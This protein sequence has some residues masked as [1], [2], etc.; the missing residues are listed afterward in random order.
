MVVYIYT[1]CKQIS[2]KFLFH[3]TPLYE[4]TIQ[5]I[6]SCIFFK[7]FWPSLFH[8]KTKIKSLK[9]I[10][11]KYP[12]N[13]LHLEKWPVIPTPYKT[14]HTQNFNR[15]STKSDQLQPKVNHTSLPLPR[16]K[17]QRSA[18]LAITAQLETHFRSASACRFRQIEQRVLPK[19]VAA[20]EIRGRRPRP[21]DF[22]SRLKSAESRALIARAIIRRSAK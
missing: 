21:G 5:L 1:F 11:Y 16:A 14:F 19:C 4:S 12:E 17:S 18:I 15:L 2:I 22:R 8:K 3:Y 10:M 7:I 13:L 20:L 6:L 9:K